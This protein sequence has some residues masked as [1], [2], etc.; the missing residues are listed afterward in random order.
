M[1]IIFY[2]RS[3]KAM[4]DFHITKTILQKEIKFSVIIPARNEDKNIGL[5][6]NSLQ[7]QTYPKELFEI[8][9]VDDHS[10]DNTAQIVK[11]FSDIKCISLKDDQINSYKK[12]AIETGIAAAQNEWIVCTDADCVTPINWLIIYSSFINKYHPSFIAAPV[13]LVSSLEADHSKLNILQIFQ[14]LDFITLQGITGASVFKK[15]HNMCNGANLAYRK[16]AFYEVG[17]FKGIDDIASGDDMLLMYKIWKKYPDGV[18]Y[19]KSKEVIVETLS[20]DNW[21]AFFNQRIRWA[22]KAK[23]YEDKRIFSVLLLVYL[24]NFSFFILLIITVFNIKYLYLLLVFWILK[25]VIE[26]PFISNVSRFFNKQNLLKYF[27]LFQPLHISY[28][29]IAGFMGS[30]GKYE[31]K[32]RRVR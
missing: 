10:T 32:G 12:K 13:K 16:E 20:A 4:P 19:L 31:W 30:L 25:T 22:S 29:I 23:Y 7:N 28:T 8:I 26:C 3:W 1:I 6:L 2:N 17:G 11:T 21:K 14:S 24:F 15:A 9:V 5:L 27:F 18:H